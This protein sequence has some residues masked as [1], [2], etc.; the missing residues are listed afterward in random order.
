MLVD[1]N[2]YFTQDHLRDFFKSKLS[3][4]NGGGIDNLT[5]KRIFE[6]YENDFAA[7]A[8]KCLNGSYKFSC[9]REK[10]ILKGNN[11]FPRIISIP[12][13]RDRLVLGILNEY[14]QEVYKEKGYNQSIP[15]REIRNLITYLQSQ[16]KHSPIAF[17]KTDFHNYYG[18][19]KRDVLLE[20]LKPDI[21]PNMLE[22]ICRA[23]STPT[24]PYGTNS[25]KSKTRRNGIPQGLSISNILAYIYLKEFDEKYGRMWADLYIRY[26]DDILFINPKV[27]FLLKKMKKCL[28]ALGLNIKFAN[29][30][31]FDGIIGKDQL[32][33][34]GYNIKNNDI[35]SIKKANSTKFITRIAGIAKKCLEGWRDKS[36]RPKFIEEDENYINYYKD[37]INLKITGFKFSNHSYGWISYYQGIN[38]IQELHSIDKIIHKKILRDI[39]VYI[40]ND[41]QELVKVYYDLRYNK[42]KQ[43]LMDFDN[44]DTSYKKKIFLER[45]GFD[46]SNA[47]EEYIN[48]AYNRYLNNLIRKTELSIGKTS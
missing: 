24:I 6:L 9:F 16:P 2:N 48:V 34:I 27:P 45:K 32:E 39:P 5:P 42:G 8:E 23:I 17:L 10:L 38:D 28:S 40:K 4:K 3:Y 43:Y 1:P 37:E 21:D 25:H 44:I 11:K 19:I 22:L 15:N 35:V 30:K 18:N 26:V 31:T 29:S 12:T 20:K 41:I 13:M 46:C 33:F 36:K 47:N 7:I 14:L